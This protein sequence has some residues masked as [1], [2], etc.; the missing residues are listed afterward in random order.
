MKPFRRRRRGGVYAEFDVH[1]AEML[2]NLEA[3]LIEL[4][5]DRTGTGEASADPL[6]AQLDVDGPRSA[7]D[8]PVLARLFPD[9]YGDDEESAAE[10]R[11]FT[12]PALAASKIDNAT[13]VMQ[14][15][16]AGGLQLDGSEQSATSI[17]VE[18]DAD[19]VQAW[20]RSLTDVRLSVAVRLGLD[21]E[22]MHADA[23]DEGAALMADIYDWLGYVQESLVQALG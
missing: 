7:P 10:F 12:E 19:G 9:A 17:E 15:L 18:L 2:A 22:G 1:E 16:L 14:T 13:T 8:D 21:D 20:L 6:F 3:Q 4:V 23:D 5:S 11:R